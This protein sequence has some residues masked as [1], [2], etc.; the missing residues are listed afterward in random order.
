MVVAYGTNEY[1]FEKL[2]DPPAFEPTHCS[3]CGSAIDLWNDAYSIMGDGYRCEEC[4]LAERR[5][6]TAERSTAERTAA[7]RT[8]ADRTA[9]A[10]GA[11]PQSLPP[12]AEAVL[13]SL[14]RKIRQGTSILNDEEVAAATGI[15]LSMLPPA[16][17]ALGAAPGRTAS[18]DLIRWQSLANR[19]EQAREQMGLTIKD[20]SRRL[21]IPQYRLRA[22][23][24]SPGES[25]DA[26]MARRYIEYLEIAPWFKR[27][28]KANRELAMR[29][30]LLESGRGSKSAAGAGQRAGA[31]QARTRTA[32]VYQFRVALKD[33]KPEVWR[34]IVV[35][36]HYTFWDL[37]VAIQDA[38]GWLDYHL[39]AFR[40]PD[41]A[42]GRKIEI[43]I[44]D[45]G[46]FPGSDPCLPGWRIRIAPYF[47]APGDRCEYEYDFG[48][49]W[50]H[51]VVLDEISARDPD[52]RYPLCRDGA[53]ACPPEDCGGAG[54]YKDF[55]AAIGDPSHDEHARMLEWV[56]GRFDPAAF[57]PRAVRFDNPRKRWK[58]AFMEME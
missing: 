17:A 10:D 12:G 37:H 28:C 7:H 58:L 23:E 38:M 19:L 53:R 1:N 49:G 29:V 24:T 26:G 39:H 13:T 27:W 32:R 33:V 54:G 9:A 48:D 8:A 56:G 21:G 41:A 40:L 34:R 52:T 3:A 36:A 4:L 31:R 15:V 45:D 30:G 22:I 5:A 16:V 20:V 50:E 14:R 47:R 51:E 46:G 57:D 18:E 2:P 11:A 42:T 43:G 6:I 35:P 55:L 44:P 25:F